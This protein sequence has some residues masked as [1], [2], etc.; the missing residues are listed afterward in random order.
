MIKQNQ[1]VVLLSFFLL[2][3]SGYVFGAG[4]N[5]GSSLPVVIL[6]TGNLEDSL[7]GVWEVTNIDF[8]SIKAEISA[9]STKANKDGLAAKIRMIQDNLMGMKMTIRQ[10]HTYESQKGSNFFNGIWKLENRNFIPHCTSLETID[11][12]QS[13]VSLSATTFVAKCIYGNSVVVVT[14]SRRQ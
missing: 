11:R 1:I 6:P 13:I 2:L 9:A 10:D 5:A 14:Y 4:R 7:S 3:G 12:T 8:S